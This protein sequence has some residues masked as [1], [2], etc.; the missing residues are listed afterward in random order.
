MKI[1]FWDKKKSCFKMLD[2]QLE[3]SFRIQSDY[4]YQS[5][6][7]DFYLFKCIYY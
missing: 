7:H 6:K 5:K 1:L 3:D 4:Q 2:I